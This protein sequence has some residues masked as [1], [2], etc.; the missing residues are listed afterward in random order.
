MILRLATSAAV[1]GEGG[2]VFGVTAALA[3]C[4]V[5]QVGVVAF[6]QADKARREGRMPVPEGP[7]APSPYTPAAGTAG[8]GAGPG[9][10]L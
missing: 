3:A 1:H 6:R 2:V 8:N 4:T 9:P 7:F 5:A 10:R